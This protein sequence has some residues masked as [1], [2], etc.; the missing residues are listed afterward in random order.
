VRAGYK[1][2]DT[3]THID[4][5]ADTLEKHLSARVREL[6]PDLAK[7]K[8][9]QGWR[10]GSKRNHF[11]LAGTGAGGWRSDAA[12]VLGEAEPRENA[13][14]ASGRFMGSRQPAAEADDWDIDGRI[15]DMDAEGVDVQLMVNSGGPS[16]HENIE[17]DIEFMRAQHRWLDEVCGKHPGR[18]K[19]M[20]AVDA[21]YIAESAAE[22]RRWSRSKWA[23]GVYINL[24]VDF[25]LDHPALRPIWEAID[26]AG[27]CYVHHSFAVGYPGYRDLWRNPFLGRTAS[28]PWAA[29]R[30]VGS[31]FGS[32]MFDRYRRM[33][34][35]V[36]E[37][38][39]GWIP[40][41]IARMQDQ[42]R[43]MGFVA[44]GLSRSMEEYACSGRFFAAIVLHEGGRMGK[45]VSDYCGDQ[46]LM[47]GSDYPHDESRFP[48]SVD[49][50]LG[51]KLDP[52]LTRRILWDNPVKAF[53]EP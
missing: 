30:A 35:A 53:G 24:P 11:R 49:E 50:F 47:Y 34:F 45:L 19:S 1:V 23:A 18:L 17:V 8:V 22:V 20:I 32:G 29:M 12:R 6:I 25:P 28:H 36:L 15:R 16:G 4:L 3:D 7:V 37:S 52:A 51:W 46:L 39:F 31:F 26:E 5:S 41:W 27:L 13:R 43:Y 9:S 44:E 40:F 38:G 10:P 33:R 48:D 42:A 14:G 2:Y 21:R